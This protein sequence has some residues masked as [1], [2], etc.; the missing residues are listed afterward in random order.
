MNR[1]LV[2][3]CSLV[4]THSYEEAYINSVF[5]PINRNNITHIFAARYSRCI[6]PIKNQYK[7]SM[8]NHSWYD[9]HLQKLSID[10]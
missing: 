7:K 1:H 2:L 9:C 8:M 6:L 3:N 5:F 4:L 10:G